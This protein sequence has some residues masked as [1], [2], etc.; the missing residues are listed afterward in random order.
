LHTPSVSIPYLLIM[1][2]SVLGGW[3]LSFTI[4]LCNKALERFLFLV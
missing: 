4:I 1:R 2:F 3:N